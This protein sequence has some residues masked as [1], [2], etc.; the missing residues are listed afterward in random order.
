MKIKEIIT[1]VKDF[2]NNSI[3]NRM[4]ETGYYIFIVL[5]FILLLYVVWR[6]IKEGMYEYV[7]NRYTYKIKIIVRDEALFIYFKPFWLYPDLIDYGRIRKLGLD[8]A[9]TKAPK[10]YKNMI[11]YIYTVNTSNLK[12]YKE[13]NLV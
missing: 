7:M 2:L 4:L 1:I 3:I 13:P 10:A 9:K 11:K 6:L 5:V 12:I 8:M